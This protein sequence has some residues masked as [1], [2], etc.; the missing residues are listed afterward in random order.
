M[1]WIQYV[2]TF[3]GVLIGSGIIQFLISRK[4]KQKEDAKKDHDEII[5]KEMKDHLTS[6]NDKWKS[7]Y[8]DKNAKAIEDLIKEVRT[9]LQDREET[10]KKRY[11]EHHVAIEKLNI[12]YQKSMVELK[13]AIQKLTDNDTK[14]TDS[15]EKMS[16]KQ[17]VM[18]SASVGMIHNT[19]I[20]FTDPIIERNAVTYEELDTL[21]SLYLPYFK[22]GGNGECKRRYEDVNKLEK[23]SKEKAYEMDEKRKQVS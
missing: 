2:F 14:I 17:D 20:R 5:K 21:D 18:A 11:D 13:Q 19:L 7:D 16:D 3:L 8:C 9:G 4:D 12:E 22:L 1:D 23:I 6:V 15:L 10:G